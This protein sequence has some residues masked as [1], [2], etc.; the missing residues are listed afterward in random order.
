MIEWIMSCMTSHSFTINVNGDHVG[1]FKGMRGL[2]QGDPLYPYL[3]TFVMEV[4]SLMINRKIDQS[5]EFKF[6]W[7]CN[8]VKLTHLCFADDLM[9]FSNGDVGSVKVLNDSLMEFSGVSGLPPNMEKSVVFLVM[10][11]LIP[12]LLFLKSCLFQ[13][14][15][16]P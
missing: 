7:R 15:L 6:H 3:F 5:S 14:A 1:Y 11:L 12:S 9:I 13:L 10:F 4:L 16:F 8:K 2:R